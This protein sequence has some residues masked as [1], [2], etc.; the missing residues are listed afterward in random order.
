[1]VTVQFEAKVKNGVIQIP[2]RYLGK[3]DDHVR[4][5]L[6]VEARKNAAKN[7]LDDLM[8]N[9]V[10]VKNFSRLTRDQIYVR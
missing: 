7:Y 3:F 5:I 10:K 8:A 9:P 2:K 6:K 4:V 1:M